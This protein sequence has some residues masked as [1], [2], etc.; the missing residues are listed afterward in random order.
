MRNDSTR[1]TRAYFLGKKSDAASA[2]ESFLAEVRVDGTPSAFMSV[3]SDNEGASFVGDFG[4][5]CRKRGIKQEFTP[6]DS[7][8]YNGVVERALALINDAALAVRIQ[9]PVLYPDASAYP[10]SWV[11]AVY[12]ACHLLNRIAT[13][14]TSGGKSPYAKCGTVRL[15]P[16]GEVWPF[17]KP[18]IWKT[19][20]ANKSQPKA[21]ARYYFKPSVDHP[22]D[23]IRVVT[24]HRSILITRNV[25]K[26]HVPSAPPA[27]PQQLPPIA[28]EGKST[29][30]EG[31]IGEGA[32]SQGGGRVE[33]SDSESDPDMTEVYPPEPPATRE[34]P[35]AEP[36]AMAGGVR[37]ATLRHHQSP[38][39]SEGTISVASTAA[40][41][42]VTA[43]A[44]ATTAAPA[45]TAAISST[46][47]TEGTFPSLCGDLRRN[48]RFSASSPHC[49]ADS[50]D[51]SRGA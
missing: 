47:T 2:F 25:T 33:D 16:P 42:A 22:R 37:K 38:S 40:V 49:K 35:A 18:A 44:A 28:K 11:E 1:F 21:Q 17:L 7:P 31:A 34:A 13:T 45:V 41:A 4:K 10:S 46:A 32:S 19:K 14:A 51:P 5:L 23:C 48:W 8:K 39:P 29:A 26:Q 20:R 6:A 9:A 24:A 30:G 36:G 43:T 27:P 3:R 12:G 15:P 50:R